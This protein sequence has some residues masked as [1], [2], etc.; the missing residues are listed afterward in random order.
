MTLPRR[1]NSKSRSVMNAIARGTSS[2]RLAPRFRK[3]ERDKARSSQVGSQRSVLATHFKSASPR[4]SYE[5]RGFT[6]WNGEKK[7]YEMHWLDGWGFSQVYTG[8]FE[9]ADL[10]LTAN[11]DFMVMTG[12]ERVTFSSVFSTQ[13]S[14]LL[15]RDGGH[16]W[17]K[18]METTFRKKA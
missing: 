16:G 10:V 3:A 11:I 9:G 15:E 5:A 6:V 14:M 8:N 4:M 17:A 18:V 7:R 13:L 1:C 12:Q 2:T